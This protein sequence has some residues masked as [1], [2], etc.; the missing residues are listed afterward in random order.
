MLTGIHKTLLPVLNQV[1]ETGVMPEEWK[2]SGCSCKAKIRVISAT[3]G[4]ILIMEQ[5]RGPLESVGLTP[6]CCARP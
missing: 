2:V 6:T 1:F 3:V 5:K 4:S